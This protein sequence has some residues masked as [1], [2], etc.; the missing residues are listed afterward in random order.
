MYLY[1]EL[2]RTHELVEDM[3]RLITKLSHGE[4]IE[5]TITDHD[6]ED[7]ATLERYGIYSIPAFK[8]VSPEFRRCSKG[9]VFKGW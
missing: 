5:A 1:R 8:D 6:A 2:Y 9:C 3:A 4:K 7:R